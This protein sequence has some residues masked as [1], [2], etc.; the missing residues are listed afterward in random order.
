MYKSYFTSKEILSKGS[1]FNLVLSERSDGKTYDC[2]TTAMEDYEKDKSTL[3]YIR[4]WK[5][6]ITPE[7]YNNFMNDYQ[8]VKVVPKRYSSPIDVFSDFLF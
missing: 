7:M 4:R 2:K 1:I 5:T 3:L 8:P 6:E